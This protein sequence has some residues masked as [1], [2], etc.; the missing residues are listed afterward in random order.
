MTIFQGMFFL[1]SGKPVTHLNSNFVQNRLRRLPSRQTKHY[2]KSLA[3]EWYTGNDT[4]CCTFLY[5]ARFLQTILLISPWKSGGRGDFLVNRASLDVAARRFSQT[6]RG[7]R[8]WDGTLRL[9]VCDQLQMDHSKSFLHGLLVT[10]RAS[11]HVIQWDIARFHHCLQIAIGFI[12][13][14][15]SIVWFCLTLF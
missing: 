13:I 1:L 11:D 3:I 12:C 6:F 2:R 15:L 4:K 9:H 10:C 14:C 5:I 7:F 8:W